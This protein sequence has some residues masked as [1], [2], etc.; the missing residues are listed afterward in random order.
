MYDDAES[1]RE[2][3]NPVP[4]TCRK[5]EDKRRISRSTQA[6]FEFSVKLVKQGNK[7]YICVCSGYCI[8]ICTYRRSSNS[9]SNF[10]ERIRALSGHTSKRGA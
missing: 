1:T 4:L 3:E 7:V 10:L 6:K 8:C 2:G 9:K 5:I